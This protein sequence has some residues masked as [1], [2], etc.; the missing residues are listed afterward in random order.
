MTKLPRPKPAGTDAIAARHGQ[1]I[2]VSSARVLTMRPR[3]ILLLALALAGLFASPAGA[4][5]YDRLVAEWHEWNATMLT[6]IDESFT[7]EHTGDVW[8]TT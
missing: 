4:V 3:S 8:P 6:E 7:G 5:V 1:L 2:Y